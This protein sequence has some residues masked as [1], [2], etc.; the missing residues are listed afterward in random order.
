VN[1]TVWGYAVLWRR[2]AGFCCIEET[3]A[4]PRKKRVALHY[5][6]EQRS[7]LASIVPLEIASSNALKNLRVIPTTYIWESRW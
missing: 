6:N 1:F 3:A 4:G 7:W 2:S 5:K